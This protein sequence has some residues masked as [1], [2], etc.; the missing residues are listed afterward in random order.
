MQKGNFHLPSSAPEARKEARVSPTPHHTLN[1][2]RSARFTTQRSSALCNTVQW[3]GGK[4]EKYHFGPKM[5]SR[6]EWKDI[7]ILH[8][9]RTHIKVPLSLLN[10]DMSS[11]V[12]SGSCSCFMLVSGSLCKPLTTHNPLNWLG[13][14]TSAFHPFASALDYYSHIH[15][16]AVGRIHTGRDGLPLW[17]GLS[18]GDNSRQTDNAS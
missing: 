10:P 18:V 9:V 12:V 1:E 8:L 7:R 4:C 2:E 14:E 5:C 6:C 13:L 16:E 3:C 11:L 15:F 17:D